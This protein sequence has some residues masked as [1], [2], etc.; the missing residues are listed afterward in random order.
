MR[1]SAPNIAGPFDIA[2]KPSGELV[3]AWIAAERR[4]ADL[5]HVVYVRTRRLDGSWTKPKAVGFG[6][7]SRVVVDSEGTVFV[8]FLRPATTGDHLMVSRRRDDGSWA[9]PQL[10]SNRS[11]A[12]SFFE[13]AA[14]ATRERDH[15]MERAASHIRRRLPSPSDPVGRPWRWKRWAA[16]LTLAEG[17]PSAYVAQVAMGAD[18]TA[19]VAW[20]DEQTRARVRR[21][22]GIWRQAESIASCDNYPAR[23]LPSM[24]SGIR[25]CCATGFRDRM[26][27]ESELPSGREVGHGEG[28]RLCPTMKKT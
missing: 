26:A 13:I 15:H 1:I 10:L 17:S 25:W 27:K 9:N 6:V 21:R 28:P 24:R 23:S 2:F 3:V 22:G 4:G 14:D 18:G 7:Q 11:R 5:V 19:L 16:R 20:T 8:A 12:A